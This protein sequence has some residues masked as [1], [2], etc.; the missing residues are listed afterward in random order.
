MTFSSSCG[1][2]EPSLIIIDTDNII[3]VIYDFDELKVSPS[4]SRSIIPYFY[5]ICFRMFHP[6][7]LKK[8][9]LFNWKQLNS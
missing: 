3:S 2:Y 7:W 8:I 6:G 4:D 9:L 1:I 5:T